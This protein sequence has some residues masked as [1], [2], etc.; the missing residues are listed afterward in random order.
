M[1]KKVFI[2]GGVLFLASMLLFGTQTFAWLS[3]GASWVKQ[4]VND[5]VPVE[6]QLDQARSLVEDMAPEIRECKRVIAQKQVDLKYLDQDIT[7]LEQ[8]YQSARKRLADQAAAL[9]EHRDTYVFLGRRINRGEMTRDAKR[10]FERVK[11]AR[12]ILESKYA[13]RKALSEALASARQTMSELVEQQAHVQVKIEE[14]EARLRENEAKKAATLDLDIDTS[15]LSKVKGILADIQK[16]LDV[17][18]Q[19]IE[20]ESPLIGEEGDNLDGADDFELGDRISSWLDGP[21]EGKKV[22]QPVL[23][24]AETRIPLNPER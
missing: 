13:R 16:R 4:Q 2:T 17:E 1:F 20:N 12:S 5:T 7:Q 9:D 11:M 10:R 6:Y 8:R 24:P 18:S 22:E 19:L 3:H 14:L 23:L 15:R 21:D